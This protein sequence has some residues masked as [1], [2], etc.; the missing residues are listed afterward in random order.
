MASSTFPEAKEKPI[1]RILVLAKHS[2]LL[3][4]NMKAQLKLIEAAGNC[5]IERITEAE[6]E[7]KTAFQIKQGN[8]D[9]VLVD[10]NISLS[11]WKIEEFTL[12]TESNLHQKNNGPRIYFDGSVGEIVDKEIHHTKFSGTVGI[13]KDGKVILSKSYGDANQSTEHEAKNEPKTKIIIAS[14]TKMFTAVAITKLIEEG[15]LKYDDFLEK[16]LP[17]AFPNRELF[18]KGSITVKDLL[19]HTSGLGQFQAEPF[20]K[21]KILDFKS[22]NDYLPMLDAPEAKGIYEPDADP[23]NKF[24]YSNINYLLLGYIIQQVSGK[25]YFQY[26]KENVLPKSM[27]DTVPIRD[28]DQSYAL[29]YAP[30]PKLGCDICLMEIFPE[31]TEKYKNKYILISKELHYIRSNGESEQ[32]VIKDFERF[33]ALVSELSGTTS[34]KMI[35]FSGDQVS[36]LITLNG[37]HIPEEDSLEW[38]SDLVKSEEKS[39]LKQIASTANQLLMQFKEK[40]DSLMA[41]YQNGLA[42]VKT[43]SDFSRFK[44]EFK[45]SIKQTFKMIDEMNVAIKISLEKLKN[46]SG[47]AATEEK[48]KI[49][50]LINLLNDLSKNLD[51]SSPTGAPNLLY[52]LIINLS[53][54]TPAG[55]YR[56]TADDLLT[57]QELLWHKKIVKNPES[58]VTEGVAL[59]H[60]APS[61]L[62][63][64][65]YG[66]CT[67][68][69][70]TPMEAVG[71]DGCA[72]GALST[73][74]TYTN[75]GISI[76]TLANVEN[77]DVFTPVFLVEK[78]F[79]AACVQESNIRYLDPNV[80]PQSTQMLMTDIE[81]TLS[82]KKSSMSEEAQRVEVDSKEGRK[83][84]IQVSDQNSDFNRLMSAVLTGI[85][86]YKSDNPG[87][88]ESKISSV[89]TSIQEINLKELPN[90]DKLKALVQLIDL[91]ITNLRN[92][93]GLRLLHPKLKDVYEKA[94]D[95]ITPEVLLEVRGTK[96]A[97]VNAR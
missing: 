81:K 12:K 73:A 77:S 58:L 8:F 60:S 79:I 26:I 56:S 85:E 59:P 44:S 83:D 24:R 7:E 91:E 94:L 39:D 46:I 6:S 92:F 89:I 32:I 47:N 20:F 96:V 80:N 2:D 15:K 5:H 87:K 97:N 30:T 64:Y 50:Q 45:E 93:V 54:A 76:A 29:S 84:T 74:R 22:I 3:S 23:R 95:A 86:Q 69:K 28:A 4:E 42:S 13:V 16:F 53:I 1:V 68:A 37:G 38:L 49:R 52:S 14:I 67:W 72:P 43:D 35:H 51:S 75:A 9:I 88:S 63:H 18:I 62:S 31:N 10:N 36:G 17:E 70:G 61:E 40:M 65:S 11:A 33:Q 82:A 71:H 27:G 66:I 78:H 55:Y 25:E 34:I 19:Q 41:S 48:E 21:E 90:H 57:F